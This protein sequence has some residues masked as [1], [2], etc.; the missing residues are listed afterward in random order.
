MLNAYA[1]GISLHAKTAGE[2]NGMTVEEFNALKQTDYDRYTLLRYGAK[3]GNFGLI[4]GMQVNGFIVYSRDT[5]G[6]NFSLKEA[7]AIRKKFFELYSGL[8]PWHEKEIAEAHKNGY[9]QNPMGRIRHLP[10]LT[11]DNWG[12]RSKEE[13]RAIN[14]PVQSCLNDLLFLTLVMFY[15]KYQKWVDKKDILPFLTIHDQVLF[16]VRKDLAYDWAVNITHLMSHL[17]L[18]QM[19]KWEPQVD[20]LADAE[21]GKTLASMESVT[22]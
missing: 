18:K 22:I 4:F 13:R 21:I 15:K 1:N 6:V 10:M 14:S 11:S 16:Y 12:I 5:F 8:L 17:P 19:F 20:F 7:T 2:L 3:A 9:V